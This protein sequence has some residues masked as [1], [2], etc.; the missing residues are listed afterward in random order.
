M[1]GAKAIPEWRTTMAQQKPHAEIQANIFLKLKKR[2]KRIP[3]ETGID[4]TY[5]IESLRNDAQKMEEWLT[6]T[7]EPLEIQPQ[8]NATQGMVGNTPYAKQ[9]RK[10]PQYHHRGK[11]RS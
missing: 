7:T 3:W 10:I 4:V 2:Y 1:R 11:P 9:S 6:K 5:D 8:E